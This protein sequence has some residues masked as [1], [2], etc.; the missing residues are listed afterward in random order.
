MATDRTLQVHPESLD[1]MGLTV[2]VADKDP[3]DSRYGTVWSPSSFAAGVPVFFHDLGQGQFLGL[4]RRYWH[5]GT[6]SEDSPGY[7]ATHVEVDTPSW[8]LI[9]ASSGVT[10]TPATIPTRTSGTLRLE[11]AVSRSDFFWTLNTIVGDDNSAMVQLIRRHTNGEFYLETEEVLPTIE[12]DSQTVIFNRGIYFDAPNLYFFGSGSTDDAVYLARRAWAKVGSRSTEGVW[13]YQTD[14]GWD[15]DPAN[16]VPLVK[17][18]GGLLTTVGPMSVAPF[19]DRR[20]ITTVTA[21]G[22]DRL[23]RLYVSN[24]LNH[25]WR[26]VGTSD[27]GEEGT[28]YAGGGLYLQ[29]HLAASASL[30]ILESSANTAA[31][32]AVS[33]LQSTVSLED[34]ILT[35]WS[36]WPVPRIA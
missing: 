27:L 10:G 13:E 28:T 4:F 1:T 18:D 11:G 17:S 24:G 14:R 33:S 29:G 12:A 21:T 23:A 32:L 31:F 16:I 5:T 2:A 22:A 19:R 36:S 34:A 8:I 26:H 20:Y 3:D 35:N 7:Y 25:P 6:G 9:T 30:P 15:S